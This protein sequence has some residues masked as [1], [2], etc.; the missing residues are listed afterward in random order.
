MKNLALYCGETLK[1]LGFG[2]ETVG[3]TLDGK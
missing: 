2:Y 1:R 3:S